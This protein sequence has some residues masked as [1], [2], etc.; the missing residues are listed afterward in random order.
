MQPFVSYIPGGGWTY[1]L[2]SETT[3]D[4]NSEQF[5]IPINFMVS[6]MI[7]IGGQ[8]TQWQLAACRT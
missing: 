6:K 2:N 7:P 1:T 4:W 5:L 3:Y 8:Q